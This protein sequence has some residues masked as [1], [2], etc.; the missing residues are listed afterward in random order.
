MSELALATN[1]QV[2][3]PASPKSTDRGLH[4]AHG[5]WQGLRRFIAELRAFP[6]TMRRTNG[7]V[8]VRAALPGLRKDEVS[9]TITD[10]ALV[11][12]AEPKNGNGGPI[13][14]TGRRLIPIPNDAE[15]GPA[16]AELKNG[17]LTVSL[18][19]L[20]AR[21]HRRIPVEEIDGSPVS[22]HPL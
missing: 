14:T 15:I 8:I 12:E 9:V 7:D 18:S 13:R 10:F 4:P 19:I 1:T 6:V 16:K 20:N 5:V 22:I 17:V 11:I 21:R 3:S 2:G